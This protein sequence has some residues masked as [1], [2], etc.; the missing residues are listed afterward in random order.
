MSNK[1]FWIQKSVDG[2]L[3]LCVKTELGP[4]A[5]AKLLPFTVAKI[6]E[7]VMPFE[8]KTEAPEPDEPQA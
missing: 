5:V 2:D 6:E 8:A 3:W 7:E 1:T 4:F